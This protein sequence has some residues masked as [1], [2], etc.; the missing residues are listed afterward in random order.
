M[1]QMMADLTVDWMVAPTDKPT[2]IH[3]VVLMARPSGSWKVA[4]MDNK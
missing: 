4:Q 1:A 3:W 2:G